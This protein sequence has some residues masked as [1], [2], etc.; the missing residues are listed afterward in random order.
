[1]FKDETLNRRMKKV[2]LKLVE[3][4]EKSELT[5]EQEELLLLLLDLEKYI[6]K[7][8][9]NKDNEMSPADALKLMKDFGFTKTDLKNILTDQIKK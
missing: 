2:K 5:D 9:E 1:M 4:E 3:I 6:I 8:E 7:L